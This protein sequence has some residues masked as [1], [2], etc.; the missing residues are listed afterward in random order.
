MGVIA[1]AYGVF[2]VLEMFS[3]WIVVMLSQLC[4]FTQKSLNWTLKMAELYGM[5]MHSWVPG[6]AFHLQKHL[7]IDGA[8]AAILFKINY[9]CLKYF[10]PKV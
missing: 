8:A 2:G 6:T 10:S 1:N 5:K 3:S 9:F 7:S 4:K